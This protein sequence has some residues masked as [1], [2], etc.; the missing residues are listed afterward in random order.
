MGEING[1]NVVGQSF[2]AEYNH[3]NG[4]DVDLATYGRVNTK[5]ISFHLKTS[6]DSEDIAKI[7]INGA[8]IEDN[9]NHRFSFPEVK[10]SKDRQFYFEIESPKSSSGNAI[11]AWCNYNATYSSGSMFINRAPMKG[12]LAFI[13][14]YKLNILDTLNH[15]INK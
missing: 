4:I 12:D 9:T 7:N 1:S 13:T 5:D 8:E 14:Q 2:I 10:D 6:P 15:V 3:L 11:T